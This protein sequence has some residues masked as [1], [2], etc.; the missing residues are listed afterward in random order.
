MPMPSSTTAAKKPRSIAL[1]GPN[2]SGKS[3]LFD[4]LMSAAGMTGRRGGDIH[5]RTMT[6]ELRLG[7][8]AFMN[9]RWSIL[10]CPGSVEFTYETLGALMAVDLAVVVC[11]PAPERAPTLAPLMK[12]L[13][14][15]GVPHLIFI[16]KID[17]LS[18]R[19]RDTLTA[20]ETYS[21]SPLVLRQ[22]PI[23]DGDAVTGY[24]DVVHERAYRYCAGQPSELIAMPAQMLERGKEARAG[25][26]E[27]LADHDDV[28][29]EKILDDI[30]LSVNEIYPQLHKDQASGAIVEVLLGTATHSNGVLRLWKAL[31]HDVP[32]PMET[33]AR[34]GI[35]A[36]GQPLVQIFKSQYRPHTGKLSYARVWRGMLREGAALNGVRVSGIHLLSEGEPIKVAEADSGELVVLGRLEGV[37]TGATLAGAGA[38]EALTFPEPPPPVYALAIATPE[39]RDDVKLSGALHKITEEDPSLSVLQDGETGETLLRGQGE[40]HLSLAIRRLSN[41]YNLDIVTEAPS[42]PFKETIRRAVYQHFRLKRQTGGHGQFAD[43][44]LEIQPRRPGEGFLFVDRTVGGAVPKQYIPAIREAAEEAMQKGPFG[45]PVVDVAVVLVDGGFHSVDSSDMAF[46]SATRNGVAEG[47]AKADPV[48]LEPIHHVTVSVPN[49]FTA[50]AQ[51]LLSGRRGQILGYAERPG[52]PGWDDVEALAPAVELQDFIMELRSQTMGLGSYQH[53]FD[54][55]AEARIRTAAAGSPVPNRNRK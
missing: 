23:R 18:G 25:L 11:E 40:A 20:F 38:T 9:D 53:R 26:T 34:R 5:T 49:A 36:T 4:G 52:W 17:T 16:N 54:H 46:R 33:A 14:D 44:K 22:V 24:I 48:R 41:L 19:V 30:P 15:E 50:G 12:I 1:V 42:I 35:A 7:H 13:E 51:R 45:H 27:I 55:L 21:K 29:L 47:L 39:R 37:P 8:C 10:D 32:D 2:G 31:R 6:T 28:I 3:T 43:V